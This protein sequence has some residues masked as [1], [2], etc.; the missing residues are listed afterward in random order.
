[1]GCFLILDKDKAKFLEKK[2]STSLPLLLYIYSPYAGFWSGCTAA[3]QDAG[4]VCV[5]CPP[6]RVW[7]HPWGRWIPLLPLWRRDPSWVWDVSDGHAAMVAQYG[8]MARNDKY[9]CIVSGQYSKKILIKPIILQLIHEQLGSKPRQ[10]ASKNVR[11]Y[12][13]R[14]KNEHA[15]WLKPHSMRLK[16]FKTRGGGPVE[17]H[18]G[19][20]GVRLPG[21][22]SWGGPEIGGSKLQPKTEAKNLG[23]R[24]DT[25]GPGG[26]QSHRSEKEACTR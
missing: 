25:K 18:P 3:R 2:T 9:G 7:G 26:V 6:H 17:T 14:G 15:M 10:E 12:S 11:G 13:V 20:S 8:S 16:M 5:A 1:M 23:P 4:A 19:G 22:R 21:G 24:S